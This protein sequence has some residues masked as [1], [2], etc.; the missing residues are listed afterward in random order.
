MDT[1]TVAPERQAKK[2]GLLINR[3]YAL[4]F[5]GQAVSLIG[6]M[7]FNTTL[8]IWIAT[9]LAV[10][11]SWAPLAVSGVL[12]GAA[13]PTLLVG[14]LAGVF[15]DRS[16]KRR[17]MLAMDGLRA[18]VIALMALI[19]GAISLPFISGGHLPA[20]W[21]LGVI[22][23][24]VF[25]VN[26]AEQF[27]RPSAM[28]LIQTI[29][30]EAEQPKAI[31]LAQASGALAMILGPAI[32]APVFVAFG[33]VWAL[34]FNAVS[35]AISY[36]TIY[37]IRA[38]GDAASS[39]QKQRGSFLREFWEGVRFYFSSRV[40]VTLLI[41]IIVGVSGA[42][43][44]NALD[45]FFTTQN[46]GAST[47]VYGFVGSVYGLGAIIGSILLAMIAN[48]IG[49]ARLLWVSMALMGVL[50]MVLSRLTSIAPALALMLA[51]GF[52]NAGLNVA[53]SPLMMRET[54]QELMGRVMSI[55]QP[56]MNLAILVSTALI[57]YLASVTLRDFH[58]TWQGMNFGPIDTIWLGGGALMALSGLIIMIGLWGVDRRTREAAKVSSVADTEPM[59]RQVTT[60]AV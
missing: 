3:D 1:I 40:L 21:T 35:F 58:V 19:S 38:A 53:A 54:P 45:I 37:A 28:A 49:L 30:P 12:L 50:V 7:L 22:Y 39:G 56:V 5:S 48:R 20:F 18:V 24:V 17:M 23:A 46:L 9:K 36:L 26:A 11:Q 31:G 59:E 60:A 4:L 44:L 25:I 6:D 51:I 15:V 55:F 32:A 27:F 47:I 43:A 33:A 8:T 57:G 29:V 2:P 10:G 52:L 42:S 13:V 14:P 16:G 41:A 34:I